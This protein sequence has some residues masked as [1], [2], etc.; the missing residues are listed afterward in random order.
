[1]SEIRFGAGRIQTETIGPFGPSRISYFLHKGTFVGDTSAGHFEMPCEIATPVDPAQADGVCIF[2]PQHRFD[3]SVVRDFVFGRNFLFAG[4]AS[5]ATVEHRRA[6]KGDNEILFQFAETLKRIPHLIQRVDRIYSM[7]VS[8]SGEIVQAIYPTFGHQLFDLTIACTASY[9][10]PYTPPVITGGQNPPKRIIVFGTENEFVPQLVQDVA[11][12]TRFQHY[13]FYTVSRAPHIP[14]TPLTR[15]IHTAPPR[16]V[17]IA[18]TTPIRWDLFLRSLLVVGHTWVTK[19]EQPPPSVTLKLVG[20]PPQVA[21]DPMGNALGGIRHPALV[22]G[23][24][25]FLPTVLH[26]NWPFFGGRGNER[27]IEQLGGFDAYLSKFKQAVESLVAAR[28]LRS[29]D[30]DRLLA[31]VHLNR[32]NTFTRSYAAGLFV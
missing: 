32:A 5:H 6:G 12:N 2:E 16:P 10:K 4:G 30:A 28:F 13:R 1:M 25:T 20:D 8:D 3:G 22:T 21:L 31:N 11:Q 18:G 19:E 7:G 26:G 29:H 14:D 24:A 15:P 17:P 23:E 27:T 9:R